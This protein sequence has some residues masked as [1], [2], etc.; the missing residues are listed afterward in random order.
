MNKETKIMEEVTVVTEEMN[1]KDHFL[2]LFACLLFA[3][4]LV[5]SMF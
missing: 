4:T 5:I 3:T 1:K 2:S